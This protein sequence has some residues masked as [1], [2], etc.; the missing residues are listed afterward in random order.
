MKMKQ[1]LPRIL[2]STLTD[3]QVRAR[4]REISANVEY[5]ARHVAFVK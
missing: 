3:A 4:L 2:K 1:R 5:I